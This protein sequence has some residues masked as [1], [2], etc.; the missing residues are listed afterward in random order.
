[1]KMRIM[2]E[3]E[4]TVKHN[5]SDGDDLKKVIALFLNSNHV[6]DHF[7][8]LVPSPHNSMRKTKLLSLFYQ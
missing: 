2:D 8:K 3:N 1:M 6:P 7:L 5:K 4:N